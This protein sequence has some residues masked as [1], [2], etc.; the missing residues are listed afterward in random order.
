MDHKKFMELQIIKEKIR[1]NNYFAKKAKIKIQNKA[2]EK[3]ITKLNLHGST[4]NAIKTKISD[5]CGPINYFIGANI[6]NYMALVEWDKQN[7][8]N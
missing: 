8:K 5:F 3:V 2:I 7:K 6:I 4:K 1:D